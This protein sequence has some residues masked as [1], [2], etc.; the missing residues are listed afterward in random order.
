[1]DLREGVALLVGEAVM[2]AD[3][4]AM[5]LREVIVALQVG[6]VEGKVVMHAD[7]VAMHTDEVA[8]KVAT[9]LSVD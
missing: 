3:K 4:V 9:D 5:D 6:N 2:H 8:H 1:M 7:K